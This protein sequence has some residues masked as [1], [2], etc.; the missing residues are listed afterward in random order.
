MTESNKGKKKVKEARRTMKDRKWNK[1][2][3]AN[4]GLGWR[5]GN[6]KRGGKER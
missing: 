4:R 3:C 1:N 5:V 2:P 6:Q